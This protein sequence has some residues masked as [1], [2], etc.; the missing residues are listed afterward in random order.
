MQFFPTRQIF[1]S[2]G[3]NLHVTWYAVLI[4]SG[5]F[6]A[7]FLSRY[8]FKKNKYPLEYLDDLFLIVLWT[9]I[10]GARLWFCA[11]YDLSYYLSNPLEIIAVWD[12]GLAIQGGFIFAII[13]AFIYTK[14]HN[15]SF[16]RIADM[17]APNVLLAQ[18]I[19]RW[20]NFVNKECFGFEVDSSYFDGFLSFL[21]EG[22]YINGHYYEPMFFYESLGCVLGFILIIFVLKRFQNKRG[23]LLWAYFMWYGLIRFFIEGHRQD[24]LMLGPLRMAQV[25]SIIYLLIGLLGFVGLFERFFKRPRPTI[26]FDLDGTLLDT[27]EGI[28]ESYT[29]VFKKHGKLDLLTD[30]VKIEFLGPTLEEIFQKYIPEIDTETLC[31]EYRLHN[32]SIF[33]KVNKPMPNAEKLLKYLNDNHYHVG[34]VSTKRHETIKMNLELFKLDSYIEAIVGCDDVINQKPSPDGINKIMKEKHWSRDELLYIGDSVGDVKAGI[35]A[36]AYTI[37]FL[38]NKGKEEALKKAGANEYINDLIKIEDILKEDH[39]FTYRKR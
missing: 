34:I 9:G 33:A 1:L 11:F 35:N 14:R 8:F 5:A 7:Y 3:D 15:L 18:A 26:L 31:E 10:I 12:G 30:D 37:G 16:L 27:Q 25:T 2:I 38:F 20:G 28:L 22:M 19:G 32:N 6:L 36:D 23:D 4:I 39:Y 21:K 17:I 13:A 29:E 24:S